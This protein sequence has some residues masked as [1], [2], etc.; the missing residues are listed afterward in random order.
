MFSAL[1]LEFVFI[2]NS[3][4]YLVLFSLSKYVYT[5]LKRYVH[6]DKV[7][8]KPVNFYSCTETQSELSHSNH[9]TDCL[10]DHEFS[11]FRLLSCR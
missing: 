7:S 10:L 11:L 3:F 6:V 2:C 8:D 1:L 4:L 9:T 5:G